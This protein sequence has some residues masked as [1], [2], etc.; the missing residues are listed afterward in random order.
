MGYTTIL[1]ILGAAIIGGL[2]LLNLLKMNENV[3]QVDN[4]TGHDVN[5]QV[6][7]VNVA[8]VIES[9]FNKIGYCADPEKINDDPKVIFGDTSSIRFI[10]D[11]DKNG[12][13]DTVFYF[14]SG[15]SAVSSTPNPRDRILYRKVNSDFPFILSNN[16]TEFKLQYLDAFKDTLST[17]LSSPSLANY[18]KISFRVEDPFA[19][20]EKY[21]EAFWR[22]LTVTSKNLRRN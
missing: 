18:I 14:V 3:Y 11:V 8:D 5:L 10:F 22:R 13:Y 15:T 7:V 9:D 20:D 1:D 4:A 12:S 16:I 21:V 6:E 17:P 2:L 19:Y